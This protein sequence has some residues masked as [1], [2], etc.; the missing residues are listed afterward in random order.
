M[1]HPDSESRLIELET[2]AAFQDDLLEALNRTV[3]DQQL[4][5][6]TLQRQLQLIYE[7]VRTLSPSQLAATSEQERPP[8]Y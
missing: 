2:K 6:D 5:I 8:H 3:A 4:Q 7:Q 1:T